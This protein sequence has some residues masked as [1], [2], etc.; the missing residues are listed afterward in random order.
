MKFIRMPEVI[1]HNW[2]QSVVIIAEVDRLDSYN[3]DRDGT[4][5]RKDFDLIWRPKRVPGCIQTSVYDRPRPMDAAESLAEIGRQFL[6]M[7]N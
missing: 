7:S 4:I 3:P 1:F 2:D 5:Y 6:Y